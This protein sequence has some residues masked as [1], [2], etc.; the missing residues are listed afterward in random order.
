[1]RAAE[2]DEVPF[3]GLGILEEKHDWGQGGGH[4]GIRVIVEVWAKSRLTT[5]HA[6]GVKG[7]GG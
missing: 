6:E 4:G 1:M 7:S 3:M 5:H 2:Y